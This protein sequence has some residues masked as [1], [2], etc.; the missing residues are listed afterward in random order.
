MS[1]NLPHPF[2]PIHR[3][4]TRQAFEEEG[5]RWTVDNSE[6]RFHSSRAIQVL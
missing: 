1:S 2:S 6:S 5:G 3:R 4:T